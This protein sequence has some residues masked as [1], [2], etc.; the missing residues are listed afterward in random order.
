MQRKAI[1]IFKNLDYISIL[2]YLALV[3]MGWLNI[4][5]AVYNDE[6]NSIIDISQKYGKQLMW[7]FITF[8]FIAAIL[9]I[10]SKVYSL[11]SYFIYGLMMLVLVSVLFLGKEVNGARSWFQLG[12]IKFQPAEFAKFA[13]CLA[14]A[15]FMSRFNFKMMTFKNLIL[16]GIICFTPAALIILQ[17][18]TGSALVYTSFVLVFYRQ[19]LP[20]IILGLMFIAVAIFILT[21]ITS[22]LVTLSIILLG[23][24]LGYYIVNKNKKECFFSIIFLSIIFSLTKLCFYLFDIDKSDYKILLYSALFFLPFAL[25]YSFKKRIK[26]ALI[27]IV[28]ISGAIG[29]NSSVHYIFENVLEKHQSQRIKIMLGIESDPYGKGYNVNQSKIAIGSGGL[30]GKGF[31][32]GTQTKYDFVPEQST[33]FIFCTIGEEW[34][35]GGSF[36]VISIFLTLILRLIFLAERQRS[37]FS[38]IYGYGV[39]SIFIFHLAINIGMTI[40]LAPVIGIPLPF[41]SY[42]GSSLLSFSILLF[43]FIKLDSNRLELFG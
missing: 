7:I 42:G 32:K 6:Y 39:A 14:M 13:T 5:A 24:I 18:D 43:I 41:F 15:K 3:F 40:G 9:L 22:S 30:T 10:D 31:L 35:F 29:F 17:N 26:Y 38:R 11:G 2:L 27:S 12:F 37:R 1:N 20:G 23:G 36:V 28:I 16:L 34:G 33:D 25:I 21:L 4:Y 8:G 19:G